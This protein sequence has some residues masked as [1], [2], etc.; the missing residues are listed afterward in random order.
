MIVR[1]FL[2]WSRI[3][4]P[5]A[6]AQATDALARAYLYSDLSPGDRVE[7]EAALIRMLDDPSPLVR[8]ALAEALARAEGAPVAVIR[9]LIAEG[10]EPSAIV[11]ARSPLLSDAELVDAAAIGG[12][13]AQIAV[14]GRPGIGPEVCAAIAEIGAPA[15]CAALCGNPDADIPDFSLARMLERHGAEPEVRE[16]MLRRSE[17]P[18][19]IRQALVAAV[20]SAL[21]GFVTQRRWLE[22]ERAERV[23]REAREQATLNLLDEEADPQE[24]CAGLIAE[25]RLTPGLLLRAVVTGRDSLMIA[26]VATLAGIPMARARGVLA[27]PRGHACAALLR[28]SR[29][30]E[31]LVAAFVAARA[32]APEGAADPEERRQAARRIAARI[33]D[34]FAARQD[35]A[36]RHA[37]ALLRRIEAEIAR[38]EARALAEAMVSVDLFE[39]GAPPSPAT[40]EGEATILD[41]AA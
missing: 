15:A 41:R 34:V 7:A 24:L 6:R 4:P 40:I 20:T 32:T 1:R 39:A 23:S 38:D 9:G 2:A 17:L 28:R 29:L 30:P 18:P 35:D 26:A 8:R 19:A 14:A 27:Q 21:A 11:L 13:K 31:W 36:A 33:A 12:E 22:P 3:A 16:A 25:G 5:G 10:G 37:L